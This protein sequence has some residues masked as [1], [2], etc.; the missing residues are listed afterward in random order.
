MRRTEQKKTFISREGDNIAYR[1]LPT[2]S[3]GDI[4][5]PPFVI[6]YHRKSDFTCEASSY[7]ERLGLPNYSM[8][9]LDMD[10]S[11][12]R[13]DKVREGSDI[14]R[15]AD[16]F[17]QFIEHIKLEY[18]VREKDIS[19]I[20]HGDRA[21]VI[22]AWIVDYAA[23]ISSAVFYSPMILSKKYNDL[24]SSC[25]R[26]IC[27]FINKRLPG[28]VN[29]VTAVSSEQSKNYPLK[30]GV[31]VTDSLSRQQRWDLV[32]T[33][34]RILRS[35]FSYFVPTQV[36]L[37]DNFLTC[38]VRSLLRFYANISSDDKAV[39]IPPDLYHKDIND[40][41]LYR[42]RDF[43]AAHF[44]KPYR[45][46]SLFDSHVKGVTKD[47]YEKL[48][49]PESHAFKRVFWAVNKFALRHVGRLSTG[50][51]LG[52]ATG[53][54]SGAS[55]DYIYRNEPSGDNLIGKKIDQYYLA[56]I[57]WR[58]TR[59]RKIHVEALILLAA[60]RLAENGQK[61]RLLDVAAG[62]G[63]Y[64][65]NTVGKITH[66]IEHVLMR[67]FIESN[68]HDGNILIQQHKLAQ[69]VTFEQGNA[70]SSADLATLPRDRT[71]TIVSGFYELFSDNSL[72]LTSL[73][74]IANATQDGGYL[75]YTTKLWN[76]KLEYMA[77]V[78]ISHKPGEHWLLRRRTQGEI[79][80][81][82][83]QA[84]FVKV[85]QRMDPWGMFSVTL[86]QKKA[87]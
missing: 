55:L 39:F 12:I 20:S 69:K 16:Y 70:F 1:Y 82:V 2:E 10:D 78:L 52:L 14:S 65:L 68:V 31:L 44:Q 62:H 40:E 11:D 79:D 59:M 45:V 23:N 4:S 41:T 57:G 37:T 26:R 56:N 76:P 66:P 13:V 36:I 7:I 15:Q 71:L 3:A 67:D 22:A 74:G 54:D 75:I 53:F 30:D 87:G 72:V 85:T 46:P 80:Q 84:G 17:Q 73:E 58:C 25:K 18:G 34:E 19:I 50:I 32:Y 83:N 51:K 6:L 64:I 8:L 77:R 33:G 24:Y 38:D 9:L 29:P 28:R 43:I 63:S 48:R 5:A 27:H 60:E 21:V 35:S 47:E 61:I 81:L 49:L 42:E 86:A